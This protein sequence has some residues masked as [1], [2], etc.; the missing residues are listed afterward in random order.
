LPDYENDEDGLLREVVGEW[1]IEK[2][3]RLAAYVDIAKFVRRKFRNGSSASAGYIE[4]F[5]G[6]GR[7][8][9]R[10]TARVIDGSP[11]VAF[12]KANDGGQPFTHVLLGDM[13]ARFP[14]I[15]CERIR[16]LGGSAMPFVGT[17]SDVAKRVVT[18]ISPH[19]FH[20][21]MLDPYNLG[22]LS[23]D[24]IETLARLKRVDMLLHVSAMDLTRNLGAYTTEEKDGLD[25]FVPGWRSAISLA[26]GKVATRAAI[27]DHWGGLVQ[28]LGFKAPYYDLITGGKNHRLYWLA[29]LSRHEKA[30]EFWNAIRH[31]NGPRDMLTGLT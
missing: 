27:M 8:R 6:T 9:I 1:A 4:L 7:S 11:V 17:A 19:G 14:P 25:K 16:R 20:F 21:A 3:E 24:I 15:A 10:D 22:S 31:L 12:R 26:Q 5:C 13:D 2:H 29:F 30:Q 28:K 23:F 18:S